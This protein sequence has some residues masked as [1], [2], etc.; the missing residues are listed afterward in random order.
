MPSPCV[1]WMH[2]DASETD[3]GTD[4]LPVKETHAMSLPLTPEAV[5]TL[6]TLPQSDFP[7]ALGRYA[8]SGSLPE[9]LWR[10][11]LECAAQG[12]VFPASVIAN[13]PADKGA[14]YRS[15][16]KSRQLPRGMVVAA[17]PIPATRRNKVV[18]RVGTDGQPL[19]PRDRNEAEALLSRWKPT[20]IPPDAFMAAAGFLGSEMPKKAA[21]H[22]WEVTYEWVGKGNVVPEAVLKMLTR[23]QCKRLVEDYGS[24]GRT[25]A[26]AAGFVDIGMGVPVAQAP[27][28]SERGPRSLARPV[29]LSDLPERS[30]S[31]TR[32]KRQKS[33]G[34][35]S[36]LNEV[37][38]GVMPARSVVRT[39][40][41]KNQRKVLDACTAYL[42]QHPDRVY[43]LSDDVPMT[44]EAKRMQAMADAAREEERKRQEAARK[45]AEQRKA[46]D[47]RIR[48]VLFPMSYPK[49]FPAAREI[50]RSVIVHETNPQTHA[51]V[52]EAALRAIGHM[53]VEQGRHVAF[54]SASD[55]VTKTI[56]DIAAREMGRPVDVR[57]SR[58]AYVAFPSDDTEE[59]ESPIIRLSCVTA[60]HL[61]ATARYD[62]AVI[63]AAE[64]MLDGEPYASDM[65]RAF[66][67]LRAETIHVMVDASA[68]RV[69][70]NVAAQCGDD[71]AY[72]SAS[73]A[74]DDEADEN[75]KDNAPADADDGIDGDTRDSRA[76]DASDVESF[77]DAGSCDF[78]DRYRP[79]VSP[80]PWDGAVME[81]DV[82]AC[83]SPE[84]VL[85][86]AADIERCGVA[87][88]VIFESM[89]AGVIGNEV[90]RWQTGKA[91]V[92]VTDGTDVGVDMRGNRLVI[93]ETR[94]G[95]GHGPSCT[96]VMRWCS[97]LPDGMEIVASTSTVAA[98]IALVLDDEDVPSSAAYGVPDDLSDG[99]TARDTI[100]VWEAGRSSR[101][102]RGPLV[103]RSLV[104]LMSAACMMTSIKVPKTVR[105]ESVSEM[106]L[107]T[108]A[109]R[110]DG[111]ADWW[112][113][114]ASWIAGEVPM[115]AT[116]VRDFPEGG[117]PVIAQETAKPARPALSKKAKRK[118]KRQARAR[119]STHT[120]PVLAEVDLKA[121]GK[122]NGGTATVWE[123]FGKYRRYAMTQAFLEEMG[124]YPG[125]GGDAI[126]EVLD[127]LTRKLFGRLNGPQG[128]REMDV[129]LPF[130]TMGDGIL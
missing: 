44:A 84:H 120:V 122:T 71:V 50:T 62:V 59:L 92:L 118:A 3:S 121:L 31:A 105:G 15:T 108:A 82:L 28:V 53:V 74:E 42:R 69:I 36:L 43:L 107:V 110:F 63:D 72:A 129:G 22:V 57:L 54:V 81:R 114:M 26:L 103:P 70:G 7:D 25:V 21:P 66:V 6:A 79:I 33:M 11:V 130:V 41:A 123:L 116:P 119:A 12:I 100:R 93:L 95:R 60:R 46:E 35:K 38:G 10:R 55:I 112:K 97:L 126:D 39:Y 115:A 32:K 5:K 49:Q 24:M 8:V 90:M 27:I 64:G 88:A 19:P 58:K 87:T 96:T 111:N 127:S 75:G 80:D 128:R 29:E 30:V 117:T 13:L 52:R 2:R 23:K 99:H 76:C 89:P 109:E 91:Q 78:A 67:A 73:A 77:T 102:G 106:R 34:I 51:P 16:L 17:P 47:A 56:A 83:L 9:T 124:R 113:R 40:N 86:V 65:T 68:T 37:R 94:D 4:Y 14:T 1:A 101:G 48:A 61:D 98:D 85:S 104:T 45:R 125:D 20:N 18:V